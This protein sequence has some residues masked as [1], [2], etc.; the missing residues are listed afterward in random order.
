MA[1]KLTLIDDLDGTPIEGDGGTVN[2]SIDGA[3]YE[4]DLSAENADALR[5]VFEKYID[6]GRRVRRDGSAGSASPARAKATP[7]RL[8]AVREWAA[9]NG[10]EVSSRG[11]I[12]ADVQKAYDDAH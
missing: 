11:R 8:K 1:Q 4:I 10:H 12:P 5:A 9:E 2:F 7:E 6:A 3:N